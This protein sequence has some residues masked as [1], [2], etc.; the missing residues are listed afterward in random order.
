MNRAL[1]TFLEDGPRGTMRVVALDAKNNEL[2]RATFVEVDGTALVFTLPVRP[3]QV[4]KLAA[5][6]AVDEAMMF[7]APFEP[8]GLV[9]KGAQSFVFR[10]EILA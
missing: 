2:A 9:E 6:D 8:E 10:W 1:Q 7:S 5:V 4:S 3:S